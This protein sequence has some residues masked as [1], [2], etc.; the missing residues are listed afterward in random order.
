MKLRKFLIIVPAVFAMVSM[1]VSCTCCRIRCGTPYP[2]GYHKIAIPE[3]TFGS[4][5]EVTVAP[6]N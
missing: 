4:M 5:I 2:Y 3:A 6:K 1:L